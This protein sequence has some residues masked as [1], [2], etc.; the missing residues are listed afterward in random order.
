MPKQPKISKDMLRP[1]DVL[2]GRGKSAQ[3]YK[4]NVA[5]RALVKDRCCEYIAQNCIQRDVTCHEIIQV[6]KS[7]GG[8]FLEKINGDEEHWVQCSYP[9]MRLKVRQSMR[10]SRKGDAVPATGSRRNSGR[11]SAKLEG[12]QQPTFSRSR[13]RAR[14]A[15]HDSNRTTA[16]VSADHLERYLQGGLNDPRP[17]ELSSLTEFEQD[18]I[19]VSAVRSRAA[20]ESITGIDDERK[21][22]GRRA[23]NLEPSNTNISRT[24]GISVLDRAAPAARLLEFH[25]DRNVALLNEPASWNLRSWPME[26]SPLMVEPFHPLMAY[27]LTGQPSTRPL[28]VPSVQTPMIPQPFVQQQQLLPSLLHET[29]APVV[30][31]LAGPPDNSYLNYLLQRRRELREALAAFESSNSSGLGRYY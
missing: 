4:G 18:N 19:R 24:V 23:C 29:R 22:C 3:N 13:S 20:V 15:I 16:T 7:R 14:P 6:V 28:S 11:N 10:D 9:T 1:A 25:A 21:H 8:R 27:S 12:L 2:L 5:F 17:T 26:P 30:T 31:S